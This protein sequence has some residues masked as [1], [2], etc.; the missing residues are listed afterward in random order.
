MRDL[1]KFDCIIA[2]PVSLHV[3]EEKRGFDVVTDWLRVH[4]ISIGPYP[5]CRRVG[6]I[7][8]LCRKPTMM[9]PKTDRSMLS[10][11]ARACRLIDAIINKTTR[12][13]AR[14]HGGDL[15]ADDHTFAHRSTA[16]VSADHD[17]LLQLKSATHCP[18][19]EHTSGWKNMQSRVAG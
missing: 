19:L 2:V 6:Q 3:V 9:E 17:A 12:L 4:S 1:S 16:L 13:K 8:I 7:N 14:P 15:P 18:A 5:R 11:T 10:S